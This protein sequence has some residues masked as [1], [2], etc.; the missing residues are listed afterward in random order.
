M[1]GKIKNNEDIELYEGDNYRNFLDAETACKAIKFVMEKGRNGEIY[2]IGAS[3]SYRIGDL[4]EYCIKKTN[5]KSKI[6]IIK[7]PEFHKQVQI[8][9]FWMETH[10]LRIL[11]FDNNINIYDK[12][13][14]IL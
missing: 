1:I 8:K 14:K 2:N 3:Q 12:L 7:T 13:D 6:K 4:L 9:D 10:K 11:G 5:S